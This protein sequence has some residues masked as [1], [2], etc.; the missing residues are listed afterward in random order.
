MAYKAENV[1]TTWPFTEPWP[2][3]LPLARLAFS[4]WACTL[5]IQVLYPNLVFLQLEPTGVGL[6][7]YLKTNIKSLRESQSFRKGLKVR[8]R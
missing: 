2:N 3:F 7:S 5:G 8:G 6:R 4:L 1:Y